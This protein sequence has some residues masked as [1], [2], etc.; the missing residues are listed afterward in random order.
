VRMRQP[1]LGQG[2]LTIAFDGVPGRTY[3]LQ[4][5]ASPNGPWETLASVKADASGTGSFLET[6][7]PPSGAYYRTSYP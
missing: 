3:S 2:G 7:A 5:A 1:I 4:R 6:A